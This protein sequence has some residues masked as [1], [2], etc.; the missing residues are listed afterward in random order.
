[1]VAGGVWKERDLVRLVAGSSQRQVLVTS[2]PSGATVKFGQTVLGTTPWA[3]DL[4]SEQAVELEVS[5]PGFH[6]AKRTLPPG[7]TKSL[8]VTL[9]RAR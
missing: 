4:P 5:A 1:L 8:D 3:G 7:E 2:T 9:K 6:S